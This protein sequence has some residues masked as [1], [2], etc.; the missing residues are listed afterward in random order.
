MFEVNYL[1]PMKKIIFFLMLSL[2]SISSYSKQNY[3]VDFNIGV[4]AGLNFNKVQGK[5][6]QDLFKT[7]PHA[8][9]FM[10]L[11]K[12]KIG[13]QIEAV[14]TQ[15]NMAIDSTFHGLYQQYYRI[16]ED[17]LSYG[18]FRFQTISIPLLVN[19]KFSQKLWFQLGPQFSSTVSTLDKNKIIKSGVDVIKKNAANFVAGIWVQL[20]GDNPLLHVNFG[21]R[22]IWGVSSINN[23]TN[24]NKWHNQQ[25]QLHIGISY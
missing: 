20:G 6:W 1:Y 23:L 24:S 25:I 22:Y 13:L 12:R 10:N 7:N 8:G 9:F 21:A 11:N 18:T 17:S 16:A 19:F 4:K 3:G 5:G 2:F 14:W 15:N